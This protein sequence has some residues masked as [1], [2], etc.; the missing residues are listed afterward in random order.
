MG[1][2]AKV[3]PYMD[4]KECTKTGGDK[5][6]PPSRLWAVSFVYSDIFICTYLAGTDPAYEL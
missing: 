2:T 1:K 5:L 3:M 6:N 4:M